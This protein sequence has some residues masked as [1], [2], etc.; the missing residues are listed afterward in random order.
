MNNKNYISAPMMRSV[1]GFLRSKQLDPERLAQQAGYP[2][3]A[4]DN[5]D[6]LVDAGMYPA[7]MQAAIEHT[8]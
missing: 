1:V 7:L 5:D 3:P 6:A 2:L 4:L 8:G